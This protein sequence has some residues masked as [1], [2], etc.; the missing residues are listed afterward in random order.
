[1]ARLYRELFRC[2]TG[3]ALL[4]AQIAFA[5]ATFQFDL[6]AQ[7][8]ADSLRAV[9]R[10]THTNVLFDPPLVDGL[11]APALKAS[12]TADQAFTRLLTGTLLKGKF[13]DDTTVTI[14]RITASA[15][16]PPL[17]PPTGGR[18]AADEEGKTKSSNGFRVAQV[19]QGK[20]SGAATVEKQDEQ[21]K[22]KPTQ[23][24]EVLVT[25]SRIPLTAK[26]GAQDVK[27][28]NRE[29]I[30][31]SGQTT[32]GDFINTLPDVSV[33]MT[34]GGVFQTEGNTTGIQLHGLP[35]GTTLVLVNGRRV[36]ISGLNSSFFDLNT[37]PLATV[38]RIEVVSE[39]S[40]AIYGSDA[41]AGV[42]N[43]VLKKDLNGF[44]ANAKYGFANGTDESAANL[45]W[46]KR[47][48]RGSASIVGSFQTRSEL[49][50]FERS[51]TANNDYRSFGGPNNNFCNVQPWERVFY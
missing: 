42:V 10:I 32:V 49:D 11:R 16:P 39:G 30:E 4:T 5:Q 46:G 31:Q 50:G 51:I 7:P 47:W 15:A 40:S 18:I 23:L 20:A 41:V 43:I 3:G 45:A 37:I 14:A 8:L 44:E 38:E 6:P 27:I 17:D 36:E 29:Q 34:E 2:V 12:L 28:Y 25:G 35:V 22:R 19:D 9:G 1:M 26:E 13:L 48:D 21:D 24:Q 33:A